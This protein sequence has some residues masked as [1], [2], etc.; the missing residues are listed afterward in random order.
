MLQVG[1]ATVVGPGVD[2]FTHNQESLRFSYGPVTIGPRCLLGER[3][4]VM[5]HM[6]VEEGARLLPL[7]QGMK[8][9]VLRAGR[10]YAGNPADL[11]GSGEYSE[12]VH[13]FPHLERDIEMGDPAVLRV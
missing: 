6:V 7:A 10:A 11:V 1:D 3:A 9:M 13:E 12:V 2:I 8:G 4:A 5:E